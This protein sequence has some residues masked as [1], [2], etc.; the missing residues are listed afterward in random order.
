MLNYDRIKELKKINLPD[1]LISQLLFLNFSKTGNLSIKAMKRIMPFLEE[2]DTYNED[3]EQAGYDFR[4]MY[5]GKRSALLD[6]HEILPDIT[7]PVVRRAVS[8][9]IKVVNAIIK[10]YGSPQLICI[11]LAREMA[12]DHDERMTIKKNQDKN[13]ELNENI[14]E[15]IRELGFTPTPFDIVKYKLWKEQ[16][17]VCAY[18]GRKIS[19]DQLF[20]KDIVDIDHI[21][22]YSKCFDDSYNNKV[23]VFA[24]ENRQKGSRIPMEYL[25]NDSEKL[26]R[27]ELFSAG[28]KN[29]KKREKLLLESFTEEMKN[30]FIERNLNDTK[31]ISK[32]LYNFIRNTLEFAPSESFKRKPIRCNNGPIT[33]YLRKQ[34]RIVKSREES[35]LHHAK[36]AAVIACTTDSMINRISKYVQGREEKFSHRFPYTETVTGEHFESRDDYDKI[37]GTRIP[38]PYRFFFEE[39]EARLGN[40]PMA[41]EKLFI[42]LGYQFNEKVKPVFVSRMP[43]HSVTGAGHDAT[44]RSIKDCREGTVA[45]KTP[46]TKLV[47]D[48]KKGEIKGYHNKRDDMLLYNALCAKLAQF[49]YDAKKAFA[50]EFRKPKADGTPG[51]VVKTVKIEETQT[52]SVPITNDN[53]KTVADNGDMVRIDVYKEDK[54]F[55]FIPIYTADT[56]KETLPNKAVVIHKLYSEW[57]EMK[58]ENFLFSLYSRDLIKITDKKPIM[59]LRTTG[60]KIDI[61]SNLVYYI[62]ADTDSNRWTVISHDNSIVQSIKDNKI[63]YGKR[64]SISNVLDIKKYQVDVLGNVSEV[65]SEKRQTFDRLKK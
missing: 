21:I 3:C 4:N 10:K 29:R 2:G 1:D 25:K 34:W 62:G 44:L 23:L 12:K 54:K 55:Y 51:P 40:T 32:L 31:Y 41:N 48:F 33:S 38:Q 17:E 14:K 8:Q 30:S 27:F 61:N 28:V 42:E 52:I 13:F 58:D 37:Y 53:N 65:K 15:Q 26:H 9:T 45:S 47:W 36:D 50:D 16:S 49:N 7:N 39:L 64:I 35:D 22:P 5:K 19:I 63:K 59:T 24:E 6:P 57:K 43:H 18:S 46:L 56:K 60:E 20:D 11:E